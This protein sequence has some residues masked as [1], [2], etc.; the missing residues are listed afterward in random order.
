YIRII[1]VFY[2]SVYAMPLAQR[3]KRS[4]ALT[5]QLFTHSKEPLGIFFPFGNWKRRKQSK[6]CAVPHLFLTM[7]VDARPRLSPA[8]SSSLSVFSLVVYVVPLVLLA[9]NPTFINCLPRCAVL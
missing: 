6:S 9:A 1:Y 3:L 7:N 8:A 4:Q 5:L 2:C